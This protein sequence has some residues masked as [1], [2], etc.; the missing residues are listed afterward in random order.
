VDAELGDR[1]LAV[2]FI[3]PAGVDVVE[4]LDKSTEKVSE[5]ATR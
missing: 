4:A 2:V 1:N 3:S 5:A